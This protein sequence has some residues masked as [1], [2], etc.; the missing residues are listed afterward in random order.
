MPRYYF[1]LENKK[2]DTEGEELLDDDAARKVAVI[3]AEELGRHLAARP[4][5][6]IFTAD[7]EMLAP[8]GKQ[9]AP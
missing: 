2:P 1:G 8:A 6:N 4:L 7:G 9:P 5:I 3:V